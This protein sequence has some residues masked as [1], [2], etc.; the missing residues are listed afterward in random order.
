[1]REPTRKGAASLQVAVVLPSS[2]PRILFSK[3]INYF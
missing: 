1:M 3:Q 2:H